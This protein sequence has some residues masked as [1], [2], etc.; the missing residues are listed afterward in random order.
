MDSPCQN[1]NFTVKHKLWECELLKCFIFKPP[2][3][4]PTKPTEQEVPTDDFPELT[5]CIMIFGGAKAYN[6]KHRI[7]VAH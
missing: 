6:D 3:K 7:K 1:H 4:E 5:W 2:A